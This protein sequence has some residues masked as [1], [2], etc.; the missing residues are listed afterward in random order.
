MQKKSGDNFTAYSNNNNCKYHHL[1]LSLVSKS[2]LSKVID[3]LA[4]P[5]DGSHPLLSEQMLLAV[6]EAASKH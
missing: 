5:A 3:N 2:E 6:R 1:N 4:K